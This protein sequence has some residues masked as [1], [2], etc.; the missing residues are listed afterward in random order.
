MLATFVADGL[1]MEA[2]GGYVTVEWEPFEI[3]RRIVAVVRECVDKK[4]AGES[5]L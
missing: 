4:L 3:A 1:G 2:D 5:L